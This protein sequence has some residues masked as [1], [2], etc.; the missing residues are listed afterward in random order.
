MSTNRPCRPVED[1]EDLGGFVPGAAE[2]VRYLGVELD[3]LSR[4]KDPVVVV[5]HEAHVPGKDVDPL[6]SVVPSRFGGDLGDG[7]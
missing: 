1:A 7:G 3:R 6:V 2:P 5:E 4:S